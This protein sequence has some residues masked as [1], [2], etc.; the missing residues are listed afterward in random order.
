MPIITLSSDIGNNDFIVSAIK[1]QLLHINPFLNLVDISHTL[2]NKNFF[3]VGYICG[4]AIPHF[5]AETIH[6][7]LVNTFSTEKLSFVVAKHNNQY[8]IC[9]NNGLISML[10][11]GTPLEYAIFSFASATTINTLIITEKIIEIIKGIYANTSN[12]IKRS[13]TVPL[14]EKYNLKP[15]T[16]DAWLQCQ[17]I[18]VDNFKNIVLNITKELFEQVRKG[19]RFE[20]ALTNRTVINKISEH[21]AERPSGEAVAWFNA[22][23]YL[24]LA[25]VDGELAPLF[26]FKD[27]SENTASRGLKT[28]LAYKVIKI[29]FYEV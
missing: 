21:Y 10:T 13:T 27:F 14:V 2:S 15:L 16:N 3:Q 12:S 25:I 29:F 9:P 6:L 28:D 22:A 19:R 11:N 18:W 4:N 7:I 8:I 1:G 17:I 23:N 20:I 26:G 24:E 5:P